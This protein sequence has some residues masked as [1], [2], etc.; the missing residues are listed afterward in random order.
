MAMLLAHSPTFGL[1]LSVVLNPV[2]LNVTSSE[3]LGSSQNVQV[4]DLGSDSLLAASNVVITS[5]AGGA[6]PINNTVLKTVNQTIFQAV[7]S[8]NEALCAAAL[9]VTGLV[10]DNFGIPNR[11]TSVVL[12]SSFVNLTFDPVETNRTCRGNGSLHRVFYSGDFVIS[13]ITNA[14][15]PGQ[16][17]GLI[18]I[19]ISLP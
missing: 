7:F 5:L 19:N 8:N 2:Q 13:N 11:A 10:Q 6:A 18:T 9:S 17:V 14:V 1:N 3:L 12:S 15:A 16:Y 4:V